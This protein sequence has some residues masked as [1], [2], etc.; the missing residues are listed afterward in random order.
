MPIDNAMYDRL[1]H[2]W[3]EEGSFLNFLKAGL[4]PVRFGYMHRVLTESIGVDPGS[5]NV[6]D[7]GCGGGLLAEEFARLGC[8]VAGVDP[9]VKSI[10]EGPPTRRNCRARNRLPNRLRGATADRR[11]RVRRRVLL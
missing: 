6:L 11:L 1:S 9:S 4:N 3:W 8:R 5:L 2:T 7:V 10:E